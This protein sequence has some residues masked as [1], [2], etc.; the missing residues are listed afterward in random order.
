MLENIFF[1]NF[2]INK[3]VI[4]SFVLANKRLT[5]V[6]SETDNGST[7]HPNY[8]FLRYK[9]LMIKRIL[10][11]VLFSFCFAQAN[12]QVVFRLIGG[13]TQL[14]NTVKVQ[15]KVENFTDVAALQFSFKYDTTS[16]IFN[17][18][19]DFVLPTTSSAFN[20]PQKGQ[21]NF[22]WFSS[23]LSLEDGLSLFNLNFIAIENKQSKVA[24]DFDYTFS[25][26]D[27]TT[28]SHPYVTY[29]AGINATYLNGQVLFDKVENCQKDA[30]DIGLND[31]PYSFE[32]ANTIR[33]GTSDKLGDFE[34]IIDTGDIVFS[35]LPRTATWS[36]CTPSFLFNI[37][38]YSENKLLSFLQ[39]NYDCPHMEVDISAPFVV[40]CTSITYWVDYRNN[41]SAATDNAVIDITLD[42]FYTFVS[43][44]ITPTQLNDKKIKFDIGYVDIDGTGRFSITVQNECSGTI[45]GQAQCINAL[46]TPDEICEPVS[47]AWD[48][49][50]LK[51]EGKCKGDSVEFKIINTST[52]DIDDKDYII[53]ED[54]ILALTGKAQIGAGDSTTITQ[55]TNNHTYRLITSQSPNHPGKSF[56]TIALE[57]CDGYDSNTM[58]GSVTEFAEDDADYF[59][60]KDCQESKELAPINHVVTGHPKGYGPNFTIT[61]H[62]DLTYLIYF[63]NVADT[64]LTSLVIRDSL[65]EYLDIISVQPGASSQAYDFSLRGGNVVQFDF[66]NLSIPPNGSGFVKFRVSQ[67]PN[68]PLNT[69][70]ENTVA[71]E[72]SGNPVTTNQV[73]HTIGGD[74]ELLFL[75]VDIQNPINK[76]I[77]LNVYPNPFLTETTIVV[78]DYPKTD[79]R[80]RLYGINGSVLLE[81]S[82]QTGIFQLSRGS[83]SKGTYVFAIED[84]GIS[85]A[86]GKLIVP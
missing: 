53:I 4:L 26:L 79:L 49:A 74:S 11:I 38:N 72:M 36:V 61:S 50:S 19:S 2:L 77:K 33:Y 65:S 57:G 16:L 3:L 30:G 8:R 21:I 28:S 32:N 22:L 43:S 56:P 73:F 78:K 83:L 18:A 64:V 68:N 20:E 39:P 51:L 44:S 76:N 85:I 31:I 37:V 69:K 27:E 66:D 15:L 67:K 29:F 23:N 75:M 63:K 60:S 62:T 24:F 25:V 70:I 34:Y 54:M 82:S 81:Q 35:T 1:K 40:P 46:I 5:F 52:V 6:L 58:L 12:G 71:I 41:G 55:K 48:G 59:T 9:R 42:S 84:K 10:H 45:V 86:S 14:N 47:P 7:G 13:E 17:G 80:L